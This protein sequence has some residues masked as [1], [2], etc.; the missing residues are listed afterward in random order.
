[1]AH[2]AYERSTPGRTTLR[3]APFTAAEGKGTG[4][5]SRGTWGGKKDDR[6]EAG[7]RKGEKVEKD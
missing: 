4:E 1:M 3:G 2:Q 5:T 7:K 6:G